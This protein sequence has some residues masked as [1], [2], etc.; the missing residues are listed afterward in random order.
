MALGKTRVRLKSQK[1]DHK[2]AL[3][4]KKTKIIPNRATKL[5]ISKAEKSKKTKDHPGTQVFRS[6]VLQYR[7]GQDLWRQL[8]EKTSGGRSNRKSGSRHLETR[9]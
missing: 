7:A 1:N 2:E 9:D 5:L 3:K 4:L 8:D 6:S